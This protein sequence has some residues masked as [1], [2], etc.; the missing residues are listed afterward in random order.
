[1]SGSFAGG[2]MLTGLKQ[3]NLYHAKYSTVFYKVQKHL[4]GWKGDGEVLG[5]LSA[6]ILLHTV[7]IGARV[8]H[9][10]PPV[11]GLIVAQLQPRRERI[12]VR[13]SLGGAGAARR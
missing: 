6:R 11:Q 1:M 7:V 9:P 13:D 5:G 3:I 2:K 4:V 8:V 10:C 12:D